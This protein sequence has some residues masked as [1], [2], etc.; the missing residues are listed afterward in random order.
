M[1]EIFGARAAAL[2]FV[3][4]VETVELAQQR[5]PV[6]RVWVVAA[7]GA[8]PGPGIAGADDRVGKRVE[9][10]A[11]LLEGELHRA[12][13]LHAV[14]CDKRLGDRAADDEE[15]VIAQHHDVPVA[16]IREKPL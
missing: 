13:A 15:A 1:R 10:G 5:W 14:G 3:R 12:G 7:G 11:R 16:E 8:G 4:R 2:L 6:E 9:L